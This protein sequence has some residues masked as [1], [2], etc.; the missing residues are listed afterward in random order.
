MTWLVLWIGTLQAALPPTSGI[1]SRVVEHSGNS[2]YSIEQEVV[3]ST[4]AESINIREQWIVENEDS[5]KLIVRHPQFQLFYRYQAGQRTASNQSPHRVMDF[6]ERIFHFRKADRL[7]AFLISQNILIPQSLAKRP[8]NSLKDTDYKPDPRARLTRSGGLVTVAFGVP[9]STNGEEPGL[10]VDQEN[11]S[12]R[13]FRSREGS[14]LT[15]DQHSSF[16]SGLYF[17]RARTLRWKDGSAQINLLRVE[18]RNPRKLNL[19]LGANEAS[20]GLD[21]IPS[22]SLRALTEGFYQRFR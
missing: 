14:D 21:K 13:R 7:G 8:M 22:Q 15:A 18:A 5:M 11:F 6:I 12:I 2:A 3:L 10:W 16:A 19:S 1:L 9:A 17:P 20:S 4:G